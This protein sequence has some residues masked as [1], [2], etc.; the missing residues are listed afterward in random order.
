MGRTPHRTKES[1]ERRETGLV[2]GLAY[3]LLR[4]RNTL[5]SCVI[6]CYWLYILLLSVQ[7][8]CNKNTRTNR[9]CLG[10]VGRTPLHRIAEQPKSGER[11][12]ER[13]HARQVWHMA[14]RRNT[15]E[16]FYTCVHR[17]QLTT[18]NVQRALLL[19]AAQGISLVPAT[20]TAIVIG[21]LNRAALHP[22]HVFSLLSRPL[23]AIFVL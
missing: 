9:K 11:E 2:S 20:A 7:L 8:L 16:W 18:Y 4:R 17:D 23:F 15:L 6:H 5:R 14:Y 1:G 10:S 3:G 19:S 12:R 22:L 13:R 21:W